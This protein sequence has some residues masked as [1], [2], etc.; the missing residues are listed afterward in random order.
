M[1]L[2]CSAMEASIASWRAYSLTDY[3]LSASLS[4]V[5]LLARLA[6]PT[7]DWEL[8][9]NR[10]FYW[11]SIGGKL[12]VGIFAGFFA[13]LK[14]FE[15]KLPPCFL[16][17]AYSYKACSSYCTVNSSLHIGHRWFSI[18]DGPVSHFIRQSSWKRC[19]HVGILRTIAPLTNFSMH[20]T[21]SAA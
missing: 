11:E 16:A 2:F 17:S 12:D 10:W 20:I 6:L 21:H 1:F 7:A 8:I 19:L 13:G 9:L 5:A 14:R 18:Y 4:N 15:M 3:N